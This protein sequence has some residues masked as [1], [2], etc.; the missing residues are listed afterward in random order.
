MAA[1]AKDYYQIL[2]VGRDASSEDIKKA[3]R[4]LA[5]KH[6][7]DRNPDNPQAE[8]EFKKLSEAYEVLSDPNK[9][10]AF[11]RY[12]YEGVKGSFTGGGFSWEDFHHATE[13]DDLFGNI[14]E[15][16]FGGSMRG[17]GRRVER[18]RD[19]RVRLDLNLED[20]LFG[21][22]E[23]I[24][25]SRLEACSTC[26]GSGARP[27]TSPRACP[28]CG[29][30]GRI[31]IVQGFFS[32]ATTCDAC[33]GRGRI[34]SDPCP[35]CRGQGRR[36]QQTTLRIDVPRGV[37]TGTQLRLLGEGEAGPRGGQ[38]GDLYVV[39]AVREHKRYRRDGFNLH[40]EE[41]ISFTLASLGGELQVQTPYGPKSIKI[42]AGAQPGHVLR[43][44]NHG[45]PRGDRDDA[46]R[47]A[48]HVRLAVQ[49]PRKLTERQRELLRELARES[50]E[51]PSESR[52]FFDKVREKIEQFG[53]E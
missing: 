42:P 8:E 1:Q 38:R 44:P 35:D 32:M 6:H 47:G 5:L 2:G 50:G 33:H 21:R 16:F 18:G 53:I 51:S 13:F 49:I 19:L 39:L 43:I 20:V 26:D 9:R 24:K 37:E 7:P 34:I 3:Y 27:G 22:E 10:A 45:V 41:P 46:P 4:K 17:A 23:E 48:L 29:G 14:F 31:R 30:A 12:G 25:I 11:D 28:R 52:S 36:E 15:T 40:V